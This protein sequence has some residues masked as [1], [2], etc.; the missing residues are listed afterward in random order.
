ME[1]KK[2]YFKAGL[3]ADDDFEVQPE[4]A[5]VNSENV[6][7]ISTDKGATGRIESVGGTDLLFNAIFPSIKSIPIGGCSDEHGQWI[8][9]FVREEISAKHTAYAYNKNTGLGYLFLRYNQIQDNLRIGAFDW[10]GGR[11]HFIHSCFIVNDLLYWTNNLSEICRINIKAGIN[12]NAPGTFAD[13]YSYGASFPLPS[14]TLIR[15]PPYF[16][17]N[18]R[19][20]IANPAIQYN[21][22]RG[23]AFR[24][25]WFWTSREGERSVLSPWSK[26]IDCRDV[27]V[28]PSGP[29]QAAL[30][31]NAIDVSIGGTTVSASGIIYDKMLPDILGADLVVQFMESEKC[32]IIHSWREDNPSDTTDIATLK[33]GG[34][35]VYQFKNDQVGE[36][37]DDAYAVKPY[38][39][40]PTKAGSIELARNRLFAGN[41]TAGLNSPKTT[42]LQIVALDSIPVTSFTNVPGLPKYKS[43]SSFQFAMEWYDRFGR[44]CGVVP[45]PTAII[46]DMQYA[47]LPAVGFGGPPMISAIR[48]S[49]SNANALLEIPEYAEY[50]KIVRTRN[51]RTDFF[52]QGNFDISHLKYAWKDPATGL[53]TYS[54]I[55]N[56]ASSV[57]NLALDISWLGQHNLGYEFVEGSGDVLKIYAFSNNG[58]YIAPIIATDGQYVIVRTVINL[59]FATGPQGTLD[60]VSGRF[61]I[62]TPKTNSNTPI[63]YEIIDG[64]VSIINAGQPNRTY[65]SL[66]INLTRGDVYTVLRQRNSSLG[67]FELYEA[68]SPDDNFWMNWIREESK[69]NQVDL[70][71]EKTLLNDFVWSNVFIPGSRVNGLSS[72]EALNSSTVDAECGAISK[73]KLVSKVQEDGTVLLAICEKETVSVYLGEQSLLDTEGTAF[74]ARS[75]GVVGNKNTLQ[76]SFGTTNPES[77]VEVNGRV[78]W[79]D[80]RNGGPIQYSVN[81]LF[82]IG[83]N[84]LS[85]VCNIISQTYTSIPEGDVIKQGDRPLI[86]AG[87]DAHH[88]EVLWSIPKLLDIPPKGNL[89]DYS[90]PSIPYPYDI[91]NGQSMTLI[92]KYQNDIW[93]GKMTFYAS[94]FFR[95]GNQL[96]CVDKGYLYR[97]NS[98]TQAKFFGVQFRSKLMF[99][100]N[101]AAMAT[102][103]SIGIE[104]NTRPAFVHFRTEEP[105]VQSSDLLRNNFKKKQGVYYSKILRDRLSPNH[106]G[107]P[108]ERQMRGD[109]LY[110]RTLLIDMEFDVTDGLMYLKFVTVGYKLNSGHLK[111]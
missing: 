39:F 20:A 47:T 40:V 86:I 75:T 26:I 83:D 105:Y 14:I 56:F 23:F 64:D 30:R 106:T 70:I 32:M 104:G 34:N 13:T 76:G 50:G 78:F 51:N 58:V 4:G 53:I 38:D 96:Y 1:I 101:I 46:P 6:R 84:K 55:T 80:M 87:H 100:N 91:Y 110:G 98:A 82:P 15:K 18:P 72:F 102:Y 71:G 107:S 49:L 68:M 54:P 99:S 57:Y 109:R 89:Q 21:K 103:L 108:V 65:G 22:L 7:A 24:F 52:V 69:P 11:S 61:E 66:A 10:D 35:V 2:T 93:I 92:Y 73:L 5:W 43:G 16:F 42:S 74:I 85:R 90:N 60:P 48:L 97:N 77:V 12:S 63:F 81:G 27:V 33:V 3:N 94:L 29:S 8:V 62:Y 44:K 19:P 88:K 59:P 36:I 111:Q 17:P 37:L 28:G 25:A 41:I 95:L 9:W 31:L 45:G 79:W 67:S